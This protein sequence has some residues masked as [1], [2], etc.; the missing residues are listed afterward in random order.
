MEKH[1]PFGVHQLQLSQLF[2]SLLV[3]EPHLDPIPSPT[4]V[5]KRLDAR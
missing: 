4:A 5:E 1:A 3:S 2:V